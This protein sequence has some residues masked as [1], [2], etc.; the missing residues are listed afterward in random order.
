MMCPVKLLAFL[1]L[2]PGPLVA[3]DLATT[4]DALCRRPTVVV[5]VR[6]LSNREAAGRTIVRLSVVEALRGTAT[7]TVELVEPAGRACGR[8]L[9]GVIPGAGYL[10]FLDPTA[11]DLAATSSRALVALEP[12]L[13]AH[14]RELLAGTD[15]ARVERLAAS[16]EHASPRIRGDAALALSIAPGVEHASPAARRAMLTAL[17]H[18]L[19]RADARVAPLCS[20]AGR[21][22]GEDVADLLVPWFLGGDL[23]ALDRLVLRTLARLEPHVVAH[24]IPRVPPRRAT[25]DRI[26]RLARQLTPEQA[27]PIL[28]ALAGSDAPRGARVAAAAALLDFGAEAATLRRVGVAPADLEEARRAQPRA[29]VFR[30]IDPRRT[31]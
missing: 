18:A 8:A 10:A 11:T 9:G 15:E 22:G 19:P 3:Q 4:L 31:R 14:V 2:I 5:R 1:A 29:P 27:I 21:L 7:E 30:S 25:A 28:S 16:L 20:V 13:V 23:P 24:R 6:A 26:V 12:G 17:A